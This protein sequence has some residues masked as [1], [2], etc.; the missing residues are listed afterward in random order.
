MKPEFSESTYVFSLVNEMAKKYSFNLA[1][2]FP[3][4]YEEGR[5]GGYDAEVNIQGIPFFFQF[6][7]SN[8]LSRSNA[9]KYGVFNSSYYEF[10]I[11]A[12]KKSKQHE[13]LLNLEN[14]GNPVFYVA[15]RFHK[16]N[17]FNIHFNDNRMVSESIW[18]TA[19]EIGVLPDEKQ[20]SV[21]FDKNISSV[22]LFSEP[23][24]INSKFNSLSN[25][26]NSTNGFNIYLEYFKNSSGY[27]KYHKNTWEGL[28]NQMVYIIEKYSD[29]QSLSKG[30]IKEL[31][32]GIP[33]DK[34]KCA[35]LSRIFFG[36]EMLV[37]M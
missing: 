9:K 11:H 37:L 6:K 7:L 21:C 29:Q 14:S 12:S 30:K 5:T 1:P 2:V 10:H 4:L 8:F 31:V 23:R 16:L 27:E 19:K 26:S 13:L 25:I 28:F 22:Y 17:D 32:Q 20:H 18:L 35:T 34:L 36:A 33:E 24:E 3:S 15:P